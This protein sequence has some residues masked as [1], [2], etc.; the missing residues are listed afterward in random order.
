M[1]EPTIYDHERRLSIVESEIKQLAPRLEVFEAIAPIERQMQLLQSSVE[2]AARATEQ[3]ISKLAR[4]LGDGMGRLNDINEE[5]MRCTAEQ[6]KEKHRAE[7]A[8]L[9][10]RI[11]QAQAELEARKPLNKIKEFWLPWFAVVSGGAGC[12]A[13]V[14][15][16]AQWLIINLSK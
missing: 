12:A 1:S 3:Q 6:V 10:E 16:M 11:K 8:L 15:Q 4:D 14:W 2:T 9:S 5:N 7:V 13:L